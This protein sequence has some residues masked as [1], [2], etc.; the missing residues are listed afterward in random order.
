ML[1]CTGSLEL[2]GAARDGPRLQLVAWQFT[3]LPLIGPE[4]QVPLRCPL[5]LQTV[6]TTGLN[7]VRIPVNTGHGIGASTF[8]FDG[9]CTY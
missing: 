2:R 4:R 6:S 9:P 5:A 3:C 8:T 1:E 7:T